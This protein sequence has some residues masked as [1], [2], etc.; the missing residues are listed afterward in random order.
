MKIFKRCLVGAVTVIACF[1]Y[2][3]WVE[4]LCN[5]FDTSQI[6]SIEGVVTECTN[7][8]SSKII[9]VHYE[10][11]SVQ[12]NVDSSF[13]I[14]GKDNPI[15]LYKYNN[16]VGL[17]EN[18]LISEIYHL[19]FLYC[20]MILIICMGVMIVMFLEGTFKQ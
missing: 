10:N 14:L 11:K 19:P 15:K 4:S 3:S 9:K 8:P 20:G 18:M 5:D 7:L 1:F 13:S 6:Q 17:S 2:M 16:R 12:F